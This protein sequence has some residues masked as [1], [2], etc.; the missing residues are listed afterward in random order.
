MN[1]IR[2]TAVAI[3]VAVASAGALSAQTQETKTTTKTKVEMKGGKT[4]T[5]VGCLERREN[6]DYMLTSIRD[7]HG[8]DATRYALVTDDDLAKHVGERVRIEGK[9]VSPGNGSV[10]V[11]SDTKSEVENGKDIEVKSRTEGT[12]GALEMPFLGV[13]SL[14]TLAASCS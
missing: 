3:G 6:G 10:A 7:V 5:L 1:T 12:T 8:M 4:V 11:T 2:M 14:K 13:K 9:T